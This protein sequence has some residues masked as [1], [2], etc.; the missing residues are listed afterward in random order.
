MQPTLAGLFALGGGFASIPL[1]LHEV[2]DL[3]HWMEAKTFMDGIALGRVTPGPVVITSKFVGY[4]LQGVL[5]TATATVS[6]FLPSFLMVVVLSPFFARV[7]TFPLFARAIEG[8]LCSL[9]GLL[10][11]AALRLGLAVAWNI[12]R[13]VLAVIALGAL[14]LRIDLLWVVL[15]GVGISVLLH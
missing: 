6:I 12:P 7:R 15:A 13:I 9:V 8:V 11:S 3:R 2:V 10:V 4:I 5:G 1:T 14:L